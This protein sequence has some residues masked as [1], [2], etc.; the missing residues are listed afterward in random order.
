MFLKICVS[1]A[2][3]AT[4]SLPFQVVPDYLK[5]AIISTEDRQFYEHSGVDIKGILRAVI[6]NIWAA[7]YAEGASTITQ[8]LAKTL[9]LSSKKTLTRKIKEA[10][11]SFQLERRYTK[12]EILSFY[13]NQV[14]FGSGAYGVESAS[15]SA[16]VKRPEMR[17]A[18]PNS[19]VSS[20]PFSP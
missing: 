1:V 4:L 15:R 16:K 18:E 7:E 2:L 12:D 13:L 17:I 20:K 14:Y 3:R 5:V 6:R 19:F 10:F 8:Q 11:L 9:F